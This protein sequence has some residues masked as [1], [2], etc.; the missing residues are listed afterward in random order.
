MDRTTLDNQELRHRLPQQPQVPRQ[1]ESSDAAR[2]AVM[3]L[4]AAEERADTDERDKK[5]YGRTPDGRGA[6]PWG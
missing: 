3:E 1:A 6:R 2:N 4:N 5:T